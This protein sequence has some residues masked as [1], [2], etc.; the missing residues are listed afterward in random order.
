MFCLP[1]SESDFDSDRENSVKHFVREHLPVNKPKE[2]QTNTLWN[3]Y[4]QEVLSPYKK[5]KEQFSKLGFNFLEAVSFDDFKNNFIKYH[6][7]ILFTHC[8]TGDYEAIEFYDRLVA[9][10]EFIDAIPNMCDKVIDLSVCNPKK[11]VD[12]IK[13][14]RK[15]IVIRSS[16][17]S[18]SFM[19]WLYFYSILF[20]IIFKN[21]IQFYSNAFEQAI[22]KIFE[23]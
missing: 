15:M 23:S 3:I 4:Q 12:T 2:F 19:M 14:K 21:E 8:T 16:N 10:D 18:I 17:K 1:L 9:T 6:V 20:E 11:I 22:S 5:F 13:I 7:C